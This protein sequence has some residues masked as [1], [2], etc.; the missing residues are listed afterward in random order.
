MIAVLTGGN[1]SER[2]VSLST[3]KTITDSLDRLGLAYQL[4]DLRDTD[5]L[6]SVK[7]MNPSVALIAIHGTYGEDG[8]L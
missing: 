7:E 4:F 2:E 3:A 5:W 1:S 8:S 6:D